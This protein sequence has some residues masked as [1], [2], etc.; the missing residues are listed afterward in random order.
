MTGG[1]GS[2]TGKTRSQ[3]TYS[4]VHRGPLHQLIHI[5]PGHSTLFNFSVQVLGCLAFVLVTLFWRL[6][7]RPQPSTQSCSLN[8]FVVFTL[9]TTHFYHSDFMVLVF[10]GSSV[11]IQYVKSHISEVLLR[12]MI[13]NT[14][15]ENIF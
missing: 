5:C 14:G 3:T 15:M 6:F 2:L 7:F 1:S 10:F 12:K 9:K 11:L 4:A 13:P 8:M